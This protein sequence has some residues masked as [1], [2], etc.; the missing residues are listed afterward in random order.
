[1][2]VAAGKLITQANACIVLANQDVLQTA[3]LAGIQ[4]ALN[5]IYCVANCAALPTACDNTGRFIWIT[6]IGDYRYS[7]GTQ[8]TNDFNTNWTG[9]CVFGWGWN[10]CGGLGNNTTT[11]QSSPV[12]EISSSCNWVTVTSNTTSAGIKSDLSLWT[13]GYNNCGALGN[14]AT[15]NQSSPV[16]EISS[17]STWT[18]VGSFA[19][20]L[21]ALKCDST[22]WAW[23][24]NFCGNLGDGTKTT[25]SSPIRE[26]S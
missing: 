21:L 26:V 11:S 14:N 1:M 8:W 16:R 24:D 10:L 20:H 2:S 12:R 18:S 22:L 5:G 23:G 4:A 17:S 9:A 3:Q 7:D 25:R 19:F 15:A 6:D 13:W